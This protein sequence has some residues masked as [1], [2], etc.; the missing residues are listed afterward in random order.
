MGTLTRH[1][2]RNLQP[3]GNL[4]AIEK[5]PELVAALSRTLAVHDPRLKLVEGSASDVR[6]VLDELG[7]ASA[8]CIVSGIPF[9]LI[10]EEEV[11]RIMDGTRES[12]SGGGKLLIYQF[13]GA[14]EPVLREHFQDVRSGYELR[15]FLPAR[16]YLATN[17]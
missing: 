10:P 1:I 3:K 4:V 15:N 12:L 13:T 6:A 5:N 2:L 16:T 9:S 7:L 8:D 14:I 17:L 11:Q